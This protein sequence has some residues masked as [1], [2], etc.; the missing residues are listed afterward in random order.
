[1]HRAAVF[2]DAGYLFAQGSTLLTGTRQ[3]RERIA[4]DIP[5]VKVAIQQAVKKQSDLPLL[6]I[7]WYD[8]LRHARLSPEQ[9]ALAEHGDFKMRLGQLNSQGEQKGVDALIIT[10]MAEL[11]R[12]KAMADAVLISGDEDLRV[13]V[14]LAQQFG[15][16]VHL[17]GIKPAAGNQSHTLRQESDTNLE[18]DEVVV[19]SFLSYSAPALAPAAA[20][21]VGAGAAGANTTATAALPRAALPSNPT[22]DAQI[23]ALIAGIAPAELADLKAVFATSGQV[24]K[25]HDRKLLRLGRLYYGQPSLT[26]PERDQLRDSFIRLVKVAP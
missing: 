20:A 8:A 15:V 3:P 1:M 13:G 2:V 11:A 16:R 9:V 19:R 12:N 7:Y 21:P 14:M 18:W 25:E 24:P 5:A 26:D 4:L 10:D 6:R 22:L 23:Q 17:V